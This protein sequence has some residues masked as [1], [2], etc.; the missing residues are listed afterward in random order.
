MNIVLRKEIKKGETRVALTPNGVKE[1]VQSHPNAY[2]IVEHNAGRLSGF[3]DDDYLIAGNGRVIT[4]ESQRDMY[5]NAEIIIGVKELQQSEYSYLVHAKPGTILLCFWHVMDPA[6]REI[7]IK[8][9]LRPFWFED[10]NGVLGAMSRVTGKMSVDV[11]THYLR[12]NFVNGEFVGRGMLPEKATLTILGG[13]GELGYAAFMEATGRFQKIIILERKEKMHRFACEL[14]CERRES[15]PDNILSSLLESDAAIS[16]I[17]IPGKEAQ[18]LVSKKMMH[19]WGKKKSGA[20]WVDPSIDQGG[21][22]E[23]SRPTT[24]QD[25]VY[26]LDDTIIRYSVANMPGAI[27]H[28]STPALESALLPHLAELID[29]TIKEKGGK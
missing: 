17:H 8:K 14:N 28:D 26:I 1:I 9:N 29:K 23:E 11:A 25:P 13:A 27:P 3:Y 6:V 5:A 21:S 7:I 15:N 2:F 18:K 12:R 10:M 19:E 24:H 22:A 4:E 16:G 20:V